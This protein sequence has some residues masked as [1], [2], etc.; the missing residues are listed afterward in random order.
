MEDYSFGDVALTENE[1][2]GTFCKVTNEFFSAAEHPQGHALRCDIVGYPGMD[3]CGK[4][5][6]SHGGVA[7]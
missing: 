4:T 6:G 7:G 1:T 3:V 5:V 2:N